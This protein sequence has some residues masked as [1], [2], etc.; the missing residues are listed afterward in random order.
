MQKQ[1]KTKILL[2][3]VTGLLLV[4]ASPAEANA[5]RISK[6]QKIA[7]LALENPKQYAQIAIKAYNWNSKQFVCLSRLWGKESAWNHKADNPHSSAFGI[8]QMLK[9]TAKHPKKQIDNGLRYIQHRYDNPCN[10]W[11]FWQRHKWY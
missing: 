11:K 9:E 10:G 8:A 6:E 1:N 3:T 7:H 5:P 2:V 4:L